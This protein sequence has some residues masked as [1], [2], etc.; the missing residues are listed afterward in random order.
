MT[1]YAP[2]TLLCSDNNSLTDCRK[3]FKISEVQ[4][5]IHVS[6]VFGIHLKILICRS[7]KNKSGKALKIFKS[8]H[9]N[10]SFSYI[11]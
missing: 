3:Q 10:K 6:W 11:F 4:F 7:F 2:I 9:N 5:L 8:I 1:I